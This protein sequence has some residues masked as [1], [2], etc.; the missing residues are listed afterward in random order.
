MKNIVAIRTPEHVQ[1]PF[2]TAGIGTRALAKLIDF[3]FIFSLMIPLSL[4]NVILFELTRLTEGEWASGAEALLFITYSFLPLA[5]FLGLE[6]MMKGQ[7]PGKKFMGIRV[8]RNTG[9]HPGFFSI[10]LRNLMLIADFFPLF[11]AAGIMSMFAHPQE[12]RLGDVVAG[13]WVVME[14]KTPKPLPQ[15]VP[16]SSKELELLQA[17]PPLPTEKINAL[18]LFLQRRHH[19]DPDARAAIAQRLLNQW[20]PQIITKPGSE[21]SFLEKVYLH[22]QTRQKK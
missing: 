21:E 19:L 6:T 7:T 20:W 13:T 10:L 4:F 17:L 8:I 2:A 9:G 18:E 16:L 14:K 5:Y 15:P 22:H 1:I 11:F 12:K 3:F